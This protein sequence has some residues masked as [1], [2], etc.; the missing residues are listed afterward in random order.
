EVRRELQKIGMATITILET[1][2]I[3]GKISKFKSGKIGM[4]RVNG[5]SRK[6]GKLGNIVL[7]LR[8]LPKSLITSN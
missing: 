1:S 7:T 5:K 3:T 6:L 8:F 2:V 4:L